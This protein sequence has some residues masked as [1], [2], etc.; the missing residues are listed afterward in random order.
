MAKMA[1]RAKRAKRQSGLPYLLFLPFLQ[2]FCFYSEPLFGLDVRQA[3][4]LV[5]DST[6]DPLREQRRARQLVGHFLMELPS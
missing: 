3:V 1:K 5:D 4:L 6:T 2:L